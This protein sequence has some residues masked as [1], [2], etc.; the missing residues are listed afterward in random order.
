METWERKKGEEE[1]EEGG[2]SPMEPCGGLASE[3]KNTVFACIFMRKRHFLEFAKSNPPCEMLLKPLV[4]AHVGFPDVI[5][6]GIF[7]GIR[8]IEPDMPDVAISIGFRRFWWWCWKVLVE[9]V[10]ISRVLEGFLKA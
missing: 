1:E 10:V 4:L 9:I 8:K 5:N 6:W 2:G 3:A 7:W